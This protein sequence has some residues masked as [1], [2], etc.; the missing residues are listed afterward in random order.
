MIFSTK[1][2]LIDRVDIIDF[3]NRAEIEDALWTLYS[4][5][6]SLAINDIIEVMGTVSFFLN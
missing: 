6:N 5:T 2:Q 4:A 3:P 1:Y